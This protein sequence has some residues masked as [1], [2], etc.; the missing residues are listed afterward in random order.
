MNKSYSYISPLSK[1]QILRKWRRKL[2]ISWNVVRTISA[3]NN[4][5]TSFPFRDQRMRKTR[6]K[7]YRSNEKYESKWFPREL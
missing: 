6:L 5:S 7:L 4:T 2:L 3:N 1:V